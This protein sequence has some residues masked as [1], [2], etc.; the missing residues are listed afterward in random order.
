MEIHEKRINYHQFFEDIL[1]I[2]VDLTYNRAAVVFSAKDQLIHIFDLKPYQNYSFCDIKKSGNENI[3]DLCSQH[4]TIFH[5]PEEIANVV[6]EK[7]L[8]QSNFDNT[9]IEENNLEPIISFK[10]PRCQSKIKAVLCDHTCP[11]IGLNWIEDTTQSNGIARSNLLF[12]ID[13]EGYILVYK[14]KSVYDTKIVININRLQTNPFRDLPEEWVVL[15]PVKSPKPINDY[16]LNY[17]NLTLITLHLDNFFMFWK[18]YFINGSI[19]IVPKFEVILSKNLIYNKVVCCNDFNMLFAFH[20][21]GFDVFKIYEKPPFPKLLSLNINDLIIKRVP[22]KNK[23]KKV[24]EEIY[25]DFFIHDHSYQVLFSDIV[26]LSFKQIN[27]DKSYFFSL[28]KPE[29]SLKNDYLIIPY[30]EISSKNYILLKIDSGKLF[31][32]LKECMSNKSQY[33]VKKLVYNIIQESKFPIFFTLASHYFISNSH[34]GEIPTKKTCF[35]TSHIIDT[36]YQP[37]MILNEQ[38]LKFYNPRTNTNIFE[39]EI[40]HRKEVDDDYKI[41]K[42]INYNKILISSNHVLFILIQFYNEF[43]TIGIEIETN[44]LKKILESK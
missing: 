8:I 38:K 32:E 20:N 24:E 18:I 31:N 34:K 9:F 40:E 36:Y 30:Y 16:Y 19:S 35:K 39:H 4:Y 2:E 11:I 42:W 43:D 1:L 27:G 33:N 23:T 22:K 25:D 14:L 7:P 44:K 21:Q 17:R 15:S 6:Q 26:D 29:F 37:L 41:I 13:S 3:K 12:S 5:F 10:K 28:Q